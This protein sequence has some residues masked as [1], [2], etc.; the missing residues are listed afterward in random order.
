M[1]M[2]KYWSGIWSYIYAT[3]GSVTAADD[4][5]QDVFISAYEHLDS[6]QGKSSY[7]TWL[8]VIAR[9]RCKDHFKSA[10]IRR[11]IPVGHHQLR[12]YASDVSASAEESAIEAITGHALWRTVLT[13]KR[14]QRE[15]VI[16]RL[17][18]EMSF[19]E[20]ARVLNIPEVT[21]KARY[22]RAVMKLGERVQKEVL[23]SEL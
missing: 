17:H 20:I 16:L 23:A 1:L 15:V 10:F 8:F 19:R 2:T 21:A 9:N 18:Q 4:L 14:P 12:E 11:V 3:A 5:T 13:L 7:K 22:R 6:F